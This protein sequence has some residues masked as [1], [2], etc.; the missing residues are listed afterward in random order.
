LRTLPIRVVESRGSGEAQE[1]IGP[2]RDAI[3][4]DRLRTF[5]GHKALRARTLVLRNLRENVGRVSLSDELG[6][7]LREGKALEGRNPMS[8]SGTKQVRRGR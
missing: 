3:L 6:R 4:P 5:V 8:G 2:T 7:V 1:S